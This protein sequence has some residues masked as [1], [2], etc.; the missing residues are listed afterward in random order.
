M[1]YS[2]AS[3]PK[4]WL[5]WLL[6]GLVTA[7][8]YVP[9]LLNGGIITDDWGDIRQTWDCKGFFTCY[10]EWFPL[11]SNRPLAPLP[12]TL[13]TQIFS[14]NY[15]WYLLANTSIYL[16]AL[17]LTA[18]ALTPFLRPFARALF[19]LL[20]A[21]PCIAMPLIVSPINQLTA[22][23]AFLYWAISLK[24]LLKEDR[25]HQTI[26]YLLAYFFLLCGFLTY[27]IIL[28]LLFF[29]AFL[30]AFKDPQKLTKNWFAYSLKYILPIFI[31][32]ILVI[33]WQ[34]ALAPQ[35]FEDV[36]RLRF[37]PAHALRNLYTWVSVFA[38]Q[39]PNLFIKSLPYFSY[40]T[41]FLFAL[42][43]ALFLIGS[44]SNRIRKID[45]P[46]KWFLI[47]SL[48]SWISSSLIFILSNES[49]VS[50]G[51]QARGLSST[52]F[53]FAIVL[54]C[55]AQLACSFS[56]IRRSLCLLAICL[57]T[58]FSVFSFSIQRDK[59]IE[60]WDL[61][62][63]ILHDAVS[64]IKSQSIG[65]NAS[66]LGDV[67]RYTPNNYNRELVYSQSWD[68]P[69]A[70]VLYAQDQVRGGI[71]VDSRGRDLQ[72]LRIEQDIAT[73]NDQGKVDFS[74]LWLYDFD[75]TT[76]RGS[77]SRLNTPEDLK[78]LITNWKK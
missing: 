11:F 47:L 39:I 21:A 57:F 59:Y 42:I 1:A 18:S 44:V 2:P 55:L 29:S 76:K 63:L 6:L 78:Q 7:F 52:W 27:E 64:L 24:L 15:S 45:T 17:G 34:K 13:S 75:P 8:I 60:S 37:N 73:V 77:L 23:V 71:V 40:M 31:V 54:A 26:F 22:T 70:L 16:A 14:T 48:L 36:S 28:P 53:C 43:G 58:C 72:N 38:L 41:A 25:K 67:P 3:A 66:I 51:Y 56:N 49:A 30:P 33:V 46:E 62:L 32:L 69:A 74:N 35:F 19:V 5:I 10:K 61:Q 12:I 9:L 4:S 68:F 50:W 65:P 20:A